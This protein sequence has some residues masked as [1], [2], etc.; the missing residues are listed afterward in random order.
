MDE[1][2]PI[3][4][5]LIPFEGYFDGNGHVIS[6]YNLSRP[7]EDNVG[8]FG[9]IKNAT[10]IRVGMYKATV[11]GRNSV[12]ALV[13]RA[14]D[15]NI[16]QCYVYRGH[17][18]GTDAIG[19]LIGYLDT[20]SDAVN[21]YS[22]N[23]S[24]VGGSTVGGLIG[25]RRLSSSVVYCYSTSSNRSGATSKGG[26]I[27][28]SNLEAFA[29]STMGAQVLFQS[30]AVDLDDGEGEV[31]SSYWD[32]NAT[33]LSSSDGGTG[34]STV[35]MVTESTFIGW[36]FASIWNMQSAVNDGYPYLRVF[37]TTPTENSSSSSTDVLDRSSSD[38]SSTLYNRG[39]NDSSSSVGVLRW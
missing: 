37:P 38:S 31:I 1:Y 13:G 23:D 25:F 19:G 9:Y 18:V 30:Q 28:G 39:W 16:E 26:L 24:L 6:N 34:K 33:G 10:I 36:N 27:G 21:C 8:L 22:R 12:G 14:I 15:S 20:Q 32:V 35:A 17:I 4:S 7:L 29:F 11:T 2:I 5:E 3:G